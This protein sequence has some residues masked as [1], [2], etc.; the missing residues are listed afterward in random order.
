MSFEELKKLIEDAFL[1]P[2]T[3]LKVVFDNGGLID[4]AFKDA[5]NKDPSLLKEISKIKGHYE[6]L[7]KTKFLKKNNIDTTIPCYKKFGKLHPLSK[8]I[9]DARRILSSYGLTEVKYACIEDDLHNF[10]ALNIGEFHPSRRSHDTFYMPHGLLRTHITSSSVRAM[11]SKKFTPP[12]GVFSIGPT[13]RRDDDATHSPMFHQMDLLIVDKSISIKDLSCILMDFLKKFFGP[14][15]K[16]RFRPSYFPFTE[17][18]IELDIL[19]KEKQEW[20]QVTNMKF[21]ARQEWLEV[22]G[23][24][25]IRKNILE[26]YG[27]GD[28]RAIAFGMGIERICMIKYGIQNINDLYKNR[29]PFLEKFS[30][31]LY[32]FGGLD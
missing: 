12:F 32:D 19:F 6:K 2:T 24:G 8:S 20:I 16:F 28:C 1:D 17:P 25:M 9:E 11:E 23:G 7:Y 21:Q 14:N 27:Y 31:D 3:V 10:E 22:A 13:Y 30:I 5:K 26:E 29:Y 15:I 18:S 4:Q